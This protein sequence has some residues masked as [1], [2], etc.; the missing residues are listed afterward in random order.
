MFQ[1]THFW[2]TQEILTRGMDALSQ[3][4]KIISD[5]ISNADVP[6]FKRSE[7][8]FESMLKRSLE[9]EKIEQMKTI[10][11]KVTDERHMEFFTPVDWK[12]VQPKPHLDY[13]TTMRPDGNNVDIE[14]EMVDSSQN[15][16]TYMLAIERY[17]QNNRLLGQMMRMA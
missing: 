15:Q 11:N 2:K 9:S 16:M 13:L 8:I 3:R 10:P 12:T 6:N 1:D 7:L 14:K 17:N 5:N 4:R